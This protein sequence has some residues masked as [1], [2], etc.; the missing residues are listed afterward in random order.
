MITGIIF[1]SDLEGT[2]FENVW[3]KGYDSTLEENQDK[4]MEDFEEWCTKNASEIVATEYGNEYA[5]PY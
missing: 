2:Q 4:Y 5:I 1:P 3:V